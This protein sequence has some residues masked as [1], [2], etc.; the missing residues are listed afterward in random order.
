MVCKARARVSWGGRKGRRSWPSL[1][2]PSPGDRWRGCIKAPQGDP[3][4]PLPGQ[5]QQEQVGFRFV[6]LIAISHCVLLLAL[7]STEQGAGA[8]PLEPFLPSTARV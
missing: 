2:L 4:H 3:G 5:V 1:P 6:S 8:A 7:P